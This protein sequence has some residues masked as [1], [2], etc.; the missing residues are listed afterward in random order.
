MAEPTP[1]EPTSD[2]VLAKATA[3]FTK[4]PSVQVATSGAAGADYSPWI[5]GAYFVND[6][7]DLLLFLEAQGKSLKN[8]EHNPR[9]AF[10]VSENDAMKDF[11]QG[12]GEA[13]VLSAADHEMVMQRLLEKLPWFKLYT[14][15]C[16]VRVVTQELFVSSFSSQWFPA[17]RWA[18]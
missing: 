17:K 2:A 12:R 14:P 8:V 4:N 10:S 1:A 6:G 11:V 9:V 18:R 7:P 13:R 3:A 15:V 16:P 5:L